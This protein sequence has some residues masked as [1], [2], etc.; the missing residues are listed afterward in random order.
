M[1][2]MFVIITGRLC[3]TM[4]ATPPLLSTRCE[5]IVVTPKSARCK[6]WEI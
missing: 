3:A 5:G 1:S 4:A 6:Y 2:V